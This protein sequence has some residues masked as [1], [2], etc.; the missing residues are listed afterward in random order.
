MVRFDDPG[1]ARRSGGC[2]VMDEVAGESLRPACEARNERKSRAQSLDKQCH[3]RR[4]G[5]VKQPRGR[6]S[7]SRPR[8]SVP[9]LGKGRYR[10]GRRRVEPVLPA[11]A[12]V[13]VSLAETSR[14]GA[15]DTGDP[16]QPPAWEM[17][18]QTSG[19]R[20]SPASCSLHSPAGLD[21]SDERRDGRPMSCGQIGPSA[22]HFAVVIDLC[23]R[24]MVAGPPHACGVGG[25]CL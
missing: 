1:L 17:I 15:A 8:V 16:P 6:G 20:P 25:R 12:I 5:P 19:F 18:S 3:S 10:R 24:R 7:I 9:V 13:P 14:N 23:T 2:P 4:S 22:G 21:G 11:V